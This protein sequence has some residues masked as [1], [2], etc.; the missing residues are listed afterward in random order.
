[1]APCPTG[2][3]A[4]AFSRR[5]LLRASA[6]LLAPCLLAEPGL[7]STETPILRL[8]REWDDLQAHLNDH[9][10]SQEDFD[11]LNPDLLALE[12]AVMAE[13]VTCAADL[14]AKVLMEGMY[15]DQPEISAEIFRVCE[16]ILL[17]GG[18]A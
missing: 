1:M 8:F 4:P 15:G 14:A 12:D 6:T 3:G 2:E 11:A 9:G 5:T 7:A 16:A 13:T 10:T 17:A 18:A